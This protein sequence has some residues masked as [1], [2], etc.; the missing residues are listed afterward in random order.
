MDKI[1]DKIGDYFKFHK[2]Y[3]F[4]VSIFTGDAPF[5][6]QAKEPLGVLE[7]YLQD[8][9]AYRLTRVVRGVPSVHVKKGS[10]IRTRDRVV[11][12]L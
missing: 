8:E 9:E 10:I 6:Y 5:P 11:R 7:R 3:D 1:R 12:G 4:P 2:R